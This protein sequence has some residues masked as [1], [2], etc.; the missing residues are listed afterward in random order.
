MRFKMFDHDIQGWYI[1]ENFLPAAQ[2]PKIELM[3]RMIEK[4]REL[5]E[6]REL[7]KKW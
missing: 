3:N 1:V 6:P 7:R 2:E 4:V 5:I